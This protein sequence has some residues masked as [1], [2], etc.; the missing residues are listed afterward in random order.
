MGV[1]SISFSLE[2][3]ADFCRE[4]SASFESWQLLF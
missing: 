2:I 4:Y 1:Y 3:F